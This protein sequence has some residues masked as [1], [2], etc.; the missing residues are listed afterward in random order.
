VLFQSRIASAQNQRLFRKDVGGCAFGR[1]EISN[2]GTS[3]EFATV[4]KLF[5]QK[6]APDAIVDPSAVR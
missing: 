2:R 1:W 4:L 5:W 6:A 3:L